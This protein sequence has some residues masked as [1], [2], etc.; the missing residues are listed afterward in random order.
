MLPASPYLI[1]LL[2]YLLASFQ[3]FFPTTLSEFAASSVPI[4]VSHGSDAT[5]LGASNG[6]DATKL[7]ASGATKLG[8][9]TSNGSSNGSSNGCVLK[10]SKHVLDAL[11]EEGHSW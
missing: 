4:V 1:N 11:W 6:S 2:R 3:G 9:S 7:G 8:A 5:K 10:D